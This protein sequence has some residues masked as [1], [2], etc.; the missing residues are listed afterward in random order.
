MSWPAR[1]VS[2][3]KSPS[4]AA[5]E[6]RHGRRPKNA[7][8]KE[9]LW[10]KNLWVHFSACLRLT[11]H[12]VGTTAVKRARKTLAA[13]YLFMYVSL[14]LANEFRH[15][16]LSGQHRRMSRWYRCP[17]QNDKPSPTTAPTMAAISRSQEFT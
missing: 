9:D 1:D 16:G 6:E 3:L 13:P 8:L 5:R 17:N 4:E 10:Q 2:Y 12:K 15:T 11:A 14:R 7:G